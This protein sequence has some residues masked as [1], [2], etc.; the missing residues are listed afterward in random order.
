MYDLLIRGGK[1]V[2]GT[3]SP[4]FYGDVYIAGDVIARI[5]RARACPGGQARRIIWAEG[6]IVA[7]GFIDIH[8][9]SDDSLLVD[10]GAES[11]IRQG[12]TTEVIGNCGYSLAPA[13]GAARYVIQKDMDRFSLQV[14]W[15]SF[16]E[17]LDALDR[18][19]PYVNMAAL[20]G[21]GT[22]RT[23][24]VGEAR[25]APASYELE[26]MK[27]L[28]AE[29]MRDGAFGLSTGL[30]YPPSCYADTGELIA[31]AAVAAQYGGIYASHIR[32][33]GD[34]VEEAVGEAILIGERARVAVEISHHKASG[35]PNWGKVRHTLAMMQEARSRGVDV[36]CDVYPYTA[37]ST[38][39]DVILPGWVSD[40]GTAELIRRLKD[41]AI[42]E[43]LRGFIE[44]EEGQM[45]GW[46]KTVIAQVR[47]AKNRALEGKNLAQIAGE[48]GK[49]PFDV[50]IDLIIDEEAAVQVIRF[51]MC[52]EDVR[53]V[54]SHPISSIGSDAGA[55]STSG[56]LSAGKPHPRAYG[57]F[58]RVLARYVREEGVL[59]L[60]DAIRKMT[61]APACRLGLSRRG[62]ILPGAFADIVI[63][64]EGRITDEAT[65]ENPHRYPSG[66]DYVIVNGKVAVED[67]MVT[68]MRPGRV[69][70]KSFFIDS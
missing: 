9:H 8:S 14:G 34:R 13:V 28:T 41:P 32:D 23:A 24:V 3:G 36:A 33:E 20:V 1:I 48:L 42:R 7:P 18:A 21:H 54:L 27:Q 29:A 43:E 12:V 63:F 69:I 25:R 64:D 4:W 68:G 57:T 56:P 62:V 2:D 61:S 38:G 31:L 35:E 70:R 44:R 45:R 46:D 49:S 16:A 37:S 6:R 5:A 26:K 67:G 22:I 10:P 47:T 30:I 65:F 58:P 19:H 40:G 60:E 11:K 15:S 51:G 55:R 52:E 53:A 39:L 17:Y 59:C 66:I 50:A